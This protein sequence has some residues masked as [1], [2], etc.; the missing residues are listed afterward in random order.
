[1]ADLSVAQR[2][3][4]ARLIAA[5]PDHLLSQLE[6]LAAAMTGDRAW[7]LRDMVEAEGVDR[8]RRDAAFAPLTP[9]FRRREDGLEG[10]N[11]P[12]SAPARPGFSAMATS[13]DTGIVTAP[14]F[15]PRPPARAA[16]RRNH[17]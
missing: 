8:R 2:A 1:M 13:G 15:C 3:A 4:L 14:I 9:L 17:V 5:C 16:P 10:L 6:A 11:F 7:A 12:A